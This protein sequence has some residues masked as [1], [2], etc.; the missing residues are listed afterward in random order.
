MNKNSIGRFILGG[1]IFLLGCYLII[2]EIGITYSEWQVLQSSNNKAGQIAGI[3]L[4]T[5]LGFG[6]AY[7]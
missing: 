5:L 1:I 4:F 3:T 7:G 2:L 6:I